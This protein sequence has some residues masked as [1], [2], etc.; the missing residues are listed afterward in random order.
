[1]I[2][3]LRSELLTFRGGGGGVSGIGEGHKFGL[4]VVG[5]G[6]KVAPATGDPGTGVVPST[7]E[8]IGERIGE[9]GRVGL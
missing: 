8:S 4:D 6:M 2:V 1:V 5:G 7:G 9:R 3:K